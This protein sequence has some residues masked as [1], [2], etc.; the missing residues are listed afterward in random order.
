MPIEGTVYT[1]GLSNGT[2]TITMP[3]D[4]LT[5]VAVQFFGCG[6]GFQ[7]NPG[8]YAYPPVTLGGGVNPQRGI[9]PVT[10]KLPTS[11]LIIDVYGSSGSGVVLIH[12]GTP[13]PNAKPLTAYVA[14]LEQ[15]SFAASGSTSQTITVSMPKTSK[16]LVGIIWTQNLDTV[17]Y[18]FQLQNGVGKNLYFY[19]TQGQPMDPQDIIPLNIPDLALSFTF[20]ITASSTTDASEINFLLYYS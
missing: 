13:L 3:A 11:S 9:I 17:E 2:N 19:P 4:N 14:V 5:I 6:A 7:I 16:A 18:K 20:T 15:I 10:Y 12:Y 8:E 1:S